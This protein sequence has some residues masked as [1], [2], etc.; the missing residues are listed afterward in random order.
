[1]FLVLAVILGG[2]IFSQI[3]SEQRAISQYRQAACLNTH[4]RDAALK[5]WVDSLL[6]IERAHR[7]NLD[8]AYNS[9]RISV[10]AHYEARIARLQNIECR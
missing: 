8:P 9:T 1:M 5:E 2:V 3:G 6:L 7:R 10:F 4:E